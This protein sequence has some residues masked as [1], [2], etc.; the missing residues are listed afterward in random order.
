MPQ[1]TFKTV[2]PIRLSISSIFHLLFYPPGLIYP[3]PAAP[4]YPWLDLSFQ[5]P[6]SLFFGLHTPVAF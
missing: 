4:A 3:A 5:D 2:K 1:F 6:I